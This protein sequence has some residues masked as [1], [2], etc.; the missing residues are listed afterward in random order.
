MVARLGQVVVFLP[1]VFV[2]SQIPGSLRLGKL[3]CILFL[4]NRTLSTQTANETQDD[5]SA[6]Q[7]T[8]R[9]IVMQS[10]C[11]ICVSLELLRR[12]TQPTTPKP[13]AVTQNKYVIVTTTAVLSD[14]RM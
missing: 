9:A 4:V 13:N 1:L 2:P 12:Q 5:K 11:T 8:N 6:D 3:P 10:Q 7:P 14:M